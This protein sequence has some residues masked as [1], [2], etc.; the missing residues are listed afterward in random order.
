[1]SVSVEDPGDFGALL[2]DLLVSR[3]NLE[4]AGLERA[5]R[6][7]EG[8]GERLQILLPKLG[9]VSERDLAEALAEL[10]ELRLVGSADFPEVPLLEDRLSPRFLRE[11]HVLPISEGPEGLLLAMA[12]PLDRY[13]LDALRLISGAEVSACVAEP[14]ELEAAIERLYGQGGGGMNRLVEEVGETAEE[15]VELDLD[16]ERLKD[17]A[18]EAPVIRLVNHLI[19]KAAEAR[20]SDVHIEAFENRLRVRYRIDGV[21]VEVDPPPAR[22]RAALVS[23]IKIM[24]RLNIAERRLPQD[25]RIK[26]AIRGVPI[27]L[28]VSTIP[29]MHG[30]GVVLRIL[31]R[32]EVKLDF[33]ALGV[34]GR[35]L[36]NYE[37]ILSRP[38]GIFLVTGPTGSGKTT[39]LYAAL[40]R[41]N[42][43]DKKLL[44]VEDPIE[45]QLEGVNQIQVKPGINLTFANVLR[46]ILRQDPDIIMIGEIRD[47]E[48][49]EIAVQ[50]ALT[51]HLV[52]STL[53]TNDAAGTITRL[54]DMRVEDYLLTSTLAGVAAQR[55]V[56]R[57]CD[58]CR[59]QERALPELVEQLGLERFG[60]GSDALLWRAVGCEQCNGTG[61]R[62]RTTVIETLV[63][64]DEIRRL[65][66]RRPEAKELQ[67]AALAAGMVSMYEDGMR[68]ALGGD[69]TIEEVLRVTRDV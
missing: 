60:A 69:T 27:D 14:S 62:G 42:S 57:L 31:D 49:A 50:A 26:L 58:D 54:L 41:L 10:L 53:H 56:R 24:A 36:E 68:K 46:S 28:R 34:V 9:L 2:G 6:L 20:A 15:G 1:M 65:I 35:N 47:L 25:G 67:R 3:G 17:L 32:Q 5:R 43:P 33:G 55:L 38:N 37:E 21:L 11:S 29:T 7:S 19:S 61:Y 13:A 18:S 39:T 51:G 66:L 45:Y 12:D 23:R 30:E 44:T 40:V 64:D 52:L 22:F 16:V 63:V 8:G 48:T 4:R 59:A